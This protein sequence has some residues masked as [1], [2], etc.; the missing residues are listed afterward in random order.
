MERILVIISIFATVE[1]E[2][3]CADDHVSSPMLDVADRD[4]GEFD[5]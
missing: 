4:W 5:V 2:E 1:K 3:E